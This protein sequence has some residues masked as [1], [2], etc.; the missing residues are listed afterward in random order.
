MKR[1]R[2]STKL[3]PALREKLA[4]LIR[5][6]NYTAVAARFAGVAPS[7]VYRWLRRGRTEPTGKYRDFFIA[8]RHAEA[9]SQVS[10]VAHVIRSMPN[11]YRAAAHYLERKF[12]SLWAR[13]PPAAAVQAAPRRPPSPSAAAPPAP[14]EPPPEVMPYDI[15]QL[16]EIVAALREC[17]ALDDHPLPPPPP[18]PAQIRPA[19]PD[20]EASR[21]PPP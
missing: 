14:T 13:R 10:A 11:N 6:G 19:D 3:T 8:I 7:T 2:C 17:G 12:P 1:D 18:A 4:T 21:L 9:Y 20:A 5:A 15:F 16:N